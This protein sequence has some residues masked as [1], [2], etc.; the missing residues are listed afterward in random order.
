[1]F[2]IPLKTQRKNQKD[3]GYLSWILPV[4]PGQAPCRNEQKNPVM[5][6]A[7]LHGGLSAMG[8]RSSDRSG[9][10]HFQRTHLLCPVRPYKWSECLAEC[11]R[12]LLYICLTFPQHGEGRLCSARFRCSWSV[13]FSEPVPWENG[14]FPCRFQ[15]GPGSHSGI[16]QMPSDHGI[17]PE[18][19]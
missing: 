3:H 17:L 6:G 8:R 16:H 12:F 4:R 9:Q 5:W 14:L 10:L 2:R 13:D 19:R 11:F 7:F 1:M 18:S 15:C